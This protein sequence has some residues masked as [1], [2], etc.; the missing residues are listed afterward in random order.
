L[1]EV[2]M[3]I[4]IAAASAAL[5]LGF[6]HEVLAGKSKNGPSALEKKLHGAWESGRDCVGDLT[7]RSD[8]TFERRHFSPGNNKLSGTWE[9]RWNALP[10]TLVLTCKTSDE[11]DRFSVGKTSKFKVIRLDDETV[12]LADDDP[13]SQGGQPIPYTRVKK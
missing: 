12:A 10:P 6:A 9:M 8:G 13:N 11:G 3:K 2:R 1:K 7:L 4:M 5:L